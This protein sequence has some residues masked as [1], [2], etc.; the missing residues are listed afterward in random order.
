MSS[1]YSSFKSHQ[2]ITESW[3]R[4]LAE[5][6]QANTENVAA[7]AEEIQSSP[8]GQEAIQ[9]ALGSPEVQAA[10]EQAVAQLEEPELQEYRDIQTS[11]TP[12]QLP[13][14]VPGYSDPDPGGGELYGTAGITAG[15]GSVL[16]L[17]TIFNALAGTAA[18]EA[19]VAAMGATIP[20]LAV[21][22]GT[23]V[24]A[25]VL[26]TLAAYLGAQGLMH[27]ADKLT[28]EDVFARKPPKPGD[29]DYRP[30]EN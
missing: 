11:Y 10:L 30:P 5:D 27:L 18:W 3:R 6:D 29:S 21:A 22:G 23:I 12:G 13:P 4:H 26:G 1:K 9:T 14:A 15:M 20:G 8:E 25:T 16:A 7:A 17:D 2:L 24:G 28:G 19:L